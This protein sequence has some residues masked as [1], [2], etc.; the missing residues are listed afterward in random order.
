M[1]L[2]HGVFHYRQPS[3]SQSLSPRSLA[4]YPFLGLISWNYDHSVFLAVTGAGS[5]GKCARLIQPSWLLGTLTY[6]LTPCQER[7]V[8]ALELIL[9]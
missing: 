1:T 3:F 2:S 5:V 4:V 9:S 6:L 8:Q 7:V